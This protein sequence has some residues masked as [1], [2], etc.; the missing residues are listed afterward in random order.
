M[1]HPRKVTAA[2]I[3]PRCCELAARNAALNRLR[4][5]RLR[6]SLQEEDEQPAATAHE[7]CRPDATA[8]DMSVAEAGDGMDVSNQGGGA[9]K[10]GSCSDGEGGEGGEL[11]VV[12][13]DA[14][15]LLLL[16]P[17]FEYAHLD[18][19]GSCTPHLD[20][21]AAR[22]PHGGLISL[23]ATDTAALYAHY[24]QVRARA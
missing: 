13:G 10:G 22:A 20:A 11:R 3:E 12:C 5:R 15:A 19:F 4:V 1:C 16:S 9:E 14:R 18:P 24:P 23:T 6:T 2:D 17:P 8:S 7:R 21:F